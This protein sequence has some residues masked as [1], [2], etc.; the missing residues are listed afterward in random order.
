MYCD[1]IVRKNAPLPSDA[2]ISEHPPLPAD[3]RGFVSG[4]PRYVEQY[5]DRDHEGYERG[6]S[7]TDER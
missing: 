3:G 6:T 2:E 7:V 5:A 1:G 4:M